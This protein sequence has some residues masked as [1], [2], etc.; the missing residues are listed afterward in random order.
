MKNL[1][2]KQYATF[3]GLSQGYVSK[4][5]KRG[6]P[7]GKKKRINPI[8]ADKWRAE[9]I[10][11]P[12]A[13]QEKPEDNE[14]AV[15]PE[16]M[17]T[18]AQKANIGKVTRSEAER[19]LSQYKAALKKLEYEEKT[20]KLILASEVVRDATRAARIV[21]DLVSSWPARTAPIITPLTDV[22]EV[23]QAL[24]REC[25]YLLTQISEAVASEAGP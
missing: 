11:T 23:E 19:V 5:I 2:Q 20:G 12:D 7:V 24:K 10:I 18:T 25:D 14:S 13:R 22:F 17:K 8:A 15:S 1:T 16:E 4:L 6:M 21:K 3:S 9:N